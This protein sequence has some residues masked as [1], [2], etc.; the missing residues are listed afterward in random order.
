[1][2]IFLRQ[3]AL[4]VLSRILG[5]S[6][7]KLSLIPIVKALM[8]GLLKRGIISLIPGIGQI[9]FT[10]WLIVDVC[11]LL[12]RILSAFFP[13]TMRW[14]ALLGSEILD[15][16]I[17]PIV[18]L[19]EFF[20]KYHLFG[21]G[22]DNYT[23]PKIIPEGDAFKQTYSNMMPL[24]NYGIGG[25]PNTYNFSPTITS[26]T[27]I[28]GSN[29]STEDLEKAIN[30]ANNTNRAAWDKMQKDSIARSKY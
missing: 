21:F 12:W 19:T 4:V 20:K 10:V 24:S 3:T 15:V 6:L 29:L 13:N 9:V 17:H 23:A 7:T 5:T 14:I 2:A 18:S 16:I 28:N 11:K 26:N 30:N 1:M 8:G 25:T 27:T 22:K